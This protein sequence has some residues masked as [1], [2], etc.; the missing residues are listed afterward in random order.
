MEIGA[1]FATRVE[2]KIDPVIKVAETGDERKLAAE[3]GSYVV[4]PLI[5]Q[6]LDDYLEHYTD[7]FLA[8]TTEI[9]V[10]I[11][12][13]F[14]SGKSHLAKIMA[15]LV[16]NRMLQGNFACERFGARVPPDAPRR[17]S[18]LRSLARMQQCDTQVL[19]FN[20]NSLVGSQDQSLP[21][22]LLSQYY[23]ARGYSNNLIYA[24]VIEAELDRQGKLDVLHAAVE[25]RAHKPW[26]EIQRNLAFYRRYLY[27]AVC[28]IAPE[29]FPTTSDVE[30]AMKE[31]EQ[32]E[33]YNVE[34]LVET[35]LTD[36][37]AREQALRKP[38]RILLVLDESGQW[39]ENNAGRLAKL[40]AFV[41]T[42]AEKG[43]GKIWVI[44]T[45]HGDMGSIYKEARA[46][47][48]DMKKIEGRFRFKP[49]LTTEN[50]E[51]V[52]EDRLFKKTLAG[53]RE[54]EQMYG[55][56]GGVLR[57]L[58]E[59]ANTSQTLPACTPERFAVYYPFFPYQVHLIPEIVK[60][61]RSRGG[62]GEQMSGS[63]R[64]LLAITQDILRAGRRAY[65]D[66]PVG[67]LVS[68]D[69]VYHNLVGE[70]EVSPDVRTEISRIR[71]VVPGATGLTH[72]VAE[73]LYL[74]RELA[75]IPRTKDNLARL[76]AESVEDDLPTVIARLE[77][78][79]E[80]LRRAKL[81]AQI[82]EEYE[83]LTG[84]R[85]T[86]EEEVSTVEAQYR[87]QD[88]ER[89]MQKHF[90]HD[91][92]KKHWRAWLGSDTVRFHDQ[93]FNI[94]LVVDE[95]FVPGTQGHVTLHLVTPLQA[96]VGV[97]LADLENRSL[98][99][100]A[101]Q[102][103]FFLCGR[104][105]G[106]DQALTRFLAMREV[107]D[108]WKGDPHK[109]EEARKLA[110]E[111][112]LNDLPK[113]EAKVLAGI[114]D[115]LRAGYVV[116]RGASRTLAVSLG[117]N[118]GD[119]LRA[120]MATF[121]PALFPKYDKVPVRV[122]N[123][124]KA[125]MD[126]LSGAGTLPVEVK[127]LRLYDKAGS[128]DLNSPLLNELR[129]KL[130]AEQAA[131]RRVLG[132]ALTEAFEA[133]PYG[134]DPNAVRVGVAALVRAGAVKVLINKKP[135]TNPTDRDLVDALRV[136]KN[137]DRAE[138]VL[139]EVDV[140]PDVLTETR[141]FLIHLAKRRNIDE[142]PAALSEVAGELAGRLLNQA[143]TVRT[144]ASGAGFPLGEDFV[145]GEEAWHDVQALANPLHRVRELATDH[146]RLE[147]GYHA[148]EAHAEFQA[149]QATPFKEMADLKSRLEAIEHR[150]P[151]EGVEGLR[152]FLSEYREAYRQAAFTEG[153]TWK[154]LQSLREQ[155]LLTL[156]PLLEGW[157]D[158]A[159]RQLNE[160][161]ERLPD[162]VTQQA[163]EPGLY[164]TLAQ[165]LL[166]L[167]EG[168]SAES[169]PAR[170]AALPEQA[171]QAIR[172]LGVELQRQAAALKPEPVAPT[173]QVQLLRSSDVTSVTRVT[174]PEEWD[175]LQAKLDERVRA[176]LAEGYIV[177]LL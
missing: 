108:N 44:V 98:Q 40:Q 120:D 63:T 125:I 130:N 49:A 86:F 75:Y 67:T 149:K 61:L 88:R 14:G 51:L 110:Q 65:L 31:A 60:S 105:P 1:L 43:Q 172:R 156:K 48:G 99:P 129:M 91:S 4:T 16:E 76:L 74:V 53:H 87:Q 143:S 28:E 166:A 32:G 71:Q 30:R 127:S 111:R 6:Y 113:L 142:T 68:F 83:F 171:A 12:G 112:E 158:E 157:R 84:E 64:T 78:E 59:L 57:G 77:P 55:Q 8:Q 73:V 114:K 15:L 26:A 52:L 93:D 150:L 36:L 47:E 107:L 174:T 9:G 139:E 70:G 33:I 102:T 154:K 69:E 34:F 17:G 25:S 145:E 37:R 175:A 80:R 54:L 90:I 21:G 89:G 19:A 147:K 117:Q 116:F 148:I 106:Y 115:G 72:R 170:V 23:L 42:A 118:P 168:L 169:L 66:A 20:L 121:W 5:E 85:R 58:G 41:E 2:E 81:V 96:F 146:V 140:P 7:T 153:E 123:D 100:D 177:E 82:G 163:L 122:R 141:T 135:Y 46:L 161:L 126:V 45:T 35:V 132:R 24:R 173:R 124:Q 39:I 101:Q 3:I 22:L 103:I 97:A 155:A 27:E 18:I 119:A 50:I 164:D 62:R 131:G 79:L 165:P 134:W 95:G 133:P 137:F 29:L 152:L 13:Y 151:L 10:W 128:L 162:D 94:K 136:S 159:R 56:R 144:W 11:S 167:R 38:Q 109:S 104:V 176:L 138:L 160:A 92:G